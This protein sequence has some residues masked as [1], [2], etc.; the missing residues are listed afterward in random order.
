[1]PSYEEMRRRLAEE[2]ARSTSPSVAQAAQSNPMELPPSYIGG[3]LSS[4]LSSIPELI[5]S[6]PTD[7]AVAF[8][9]AH[10]VSGF[11]SQILPTAI[12]YAG[13]FRLSQTAKGAS[14]LSKGMQGAKAAG[15][16]L[17][18]N[19]ENRPVIAAAVKEM[20]RYSPLEL[21]R[22]GVGAVVNPEN[23]GELF[24]DVAI[25]TAF[26][27]GLGGIGGYLRSGGIRKRALGGSIVEGQ[28]NLF[29]HPV[30]DLR[31]ARQPEARVV[32]DEI[33]I[34][35]AQEQLT[36][37]ILNDKPIMG[38][39]SK[40]PLPLIQ[41]VEGG[42]DNTAIHLN[43][44]FK[45]N[46]RMGK[47]RPLDRRKI[48][49]GDPGDNTTLNP[50]ELEPVLKELGFATP[51]DLAENVLHARVVTIGNDRA[52]GVMG[53]LLE[54]PAVVSYGDGIFAAKTDTGATALFKRVA[55]GADEPSPVTTALDD[56]IN[57]TSPVEE[58]KAAIEL[59]E[60]T[61]ETLDDAF[62]VPG[63][64]KEFLDGKLA[65]E[66]VHKVRQGFVFQ[67]GD[68]VPA[69]D[70][71]VA[72]FRANSDAKI[73]QLQ[74]RA[75]VIE[76]E[77]AAPKVAGRPQLFTVIG[78]GK[79]LPKNDALDLINKF[80]D[81]EMNTVNKAM[82]QNERWKWSENNAVPAQPALA[83]PKAKG[84]KKISPQVSATAP[85]HPFRPGDKWVAVLTDRPGAFVRDLE[86]L[87][88]T[89]AQQWSTMRRM[90]QPVV[91]EAAHI[92]NQADDLLLRTVSPLDVARMSR[93]SRKTWVA[94]TAKEIGRRGAKIS[95]LND[96]YTLQNYADRLYDV[97]S[98]AMF[99][100]RRNTMYA[101]YSG[102]LTN[103]LRVVREKV[104]EAMF[105]KEGLKPGGRGTLGRNFERQ[106]INGKM[107]F[108]EAVD[109]LTDD[110]LDVVVKALITQTPAK[111]VKKLAQSGDISEQAF[112]AV[113]R[114]QEINAGFMNDNVLPAIRSM[115]ESSNYNLLEG[116]VIPRIL[117][118]DWRVKVADEGG[119]LVYLASGKTRSAAQRMAKAITDEAKERGLNYKAE[120]GYLKHAVEMKLDDVTDLMEDVGKRIDSDPEAADVVA[121]A[122][123]R[124]QF[125]NVKR[126]SR[127]P[128]NP[129][130]P[131]SLAHE[132]TGIKATDTTYTREEFVKAFEAHINKMGNFAA[133]Q[134]FMERWGN[135][136][137]SL[138]ETNNV[139]WKD[140][141]RRAQQAL[142][143]EGETTRWINDRL[144]KVLGPQMGAKAGTKIA[145]A[146]NATMHYF[147][148]GF[149]NP[150]FA[151]LNALSPLQT[152]LP[153]VA[154]VL[155]APFAESNLLL[156]H[157]PMFDKAGKPIGQGAFLDPLKIMWESVRQ[158]KVADE[159]LQDIHVRLRNDN[160][161][162]PMLFE[163]HVGAGASSPQTLKEAFTSGGY[164]KFLYEGST[165]MS[166]KSEEF[167]RVVSANAG[168]LVGAKHLGLEGEQLYHFTK[169][170]VES[171]N[172]LYNQSDRARIITGPIGSMFGLFKNWQMHFMGMM[173]TYAGLGIKHNTWG[174]LLWQMGTAATLG[175]LGATPL[176]HMADG[177]ANFEEHEEGDS[178]LWMQENWA[179]KAADMAWFGPMGGL[180]ISLQA[181][182]TIPGTDVRNDLQSYTNSVVL[183]RMKQLGGAVGEAWTYANTTGEN[184]LTNSNIRDQFIAAAT[185]RAVS[186]A[187]AVVE[188]NY[189]KSMS[190]GYPQL[191]DPSFTAKLAHGLGMNSVE[192]ERHQVAA[193]KLYKDQEARKRDTTYHGKAYASAI[194]AEDQDEA[195]RII[196]SAIA[197][198][199]DISSV[200]NSAGNYRRRE[201]GDLLD[202]Y[203]TESAARYR[204]IMDR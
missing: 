193:R 93:Q 178:F 5:G 66:I 187:A 11:V 176:R 200:M 10:P 38:A 65:P 153:Q 198:N 128:Y 161:L 44:I 116:Y 109:Q 124:V 186:R 132:R 85:K 168:Y 91:N 98:P 184:P 182:S 122:M 131:G 90:F 25:S 188:G 204:G 8:R 81:E 173:L 119:R 157:V 111:E 140:V 73:A 78:D 133:V 57:P 195:E 76:Q 35:A 95:G 141:M 18:M 165:W 49:E 160:T 89:N 96:N 72:A 192:V 26:A 115:G 99:K 183:E 102:L 162:H 69:T 171:T 203:K 19:V 71:L 7:P 32:G 118:G 39:I 40:K 50:G 147:Q 201:E 127:L 100:E 191:Q 158:L 103:R 130:T 151:I 166:R 110:E 154:F 14:A 55:K 170:F 51:S 59:P 68:L 185:P 117:L 12:P 88:A 1:M 105:G 48:W 21:G 164:S 47:D 197:R 199:L 56:K 30:V 152:V 174:P 97:L 180:G 80:I 23:T 169:R 137:G 196:V 163:E 45:P 24:A 13:V 142:G 82:R 6:N 34:E 43:T 27:G 139:L 4:A 15:K 53:K 145:A 112:R 175:G 177:L 202:R 86:K 52:A 121:S 3:F 22:L 37:E 54:S 136:L 120:D 61:A 144:S 146:T 77:A 46:S 17:G 194:L 2:E 64:I 33:S 28:N 67:G 125:M 29:A 31:A 108:R 87:N 155:K 107:S 179:S 148:L 123:K 63:E 41:A 134:S 60:V 70:E 106:Q 36:K 113:E 62:A 79:P 84:A 138:R 75:R 149:L 135:E 126:E 159:A 20:L 42:A 9:S 156:N 83:K 172:Y 143:V 181:S 190:T 94:E 104:N 189:I 58:A 167:A 74:A 92:Y 150:T 114:M 101:R 16:A 129:R